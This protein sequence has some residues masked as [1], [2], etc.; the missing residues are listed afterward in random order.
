MPPGLS[1]LR[2][3]I[4]WIQTPVV[5]YNLAPLEGREDAVKVS[6]LKMQALIREGS[7]PG[8]RSGDDQ[9]QSKSTSALRVRRQR[10][11]CDKAVNTQQHLDATEHSVVTTGN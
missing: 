5:V 2:T 7:L 1:P 6:I 11:S 3:V 8:E 10:D 9:A 4:R